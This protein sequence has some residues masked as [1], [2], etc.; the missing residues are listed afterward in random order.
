MFM[1]T[2]SHVPWDTY[3]WAERSPCD[4]KIA[5]KKGS[6]VAALVLVRS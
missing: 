4:W 2:R 5:K 1:M 6:E 3:E